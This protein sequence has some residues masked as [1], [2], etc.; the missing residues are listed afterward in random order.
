LGGW[1]DI[2]RAP[3]GTAMATTATRISEQERGMREQAL[4]STIANLRIEN[5]RLDDESTR[6]CLRHVDGE[7]D[8]QASAAQHGRVPSLLGGLAAGSTPMSVRQTSPLSKPEAAAS[9]LQHSTRSRRTARF[10]W[11]VYRIS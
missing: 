3:D 11:F 2:G 6:I 9:E 1:I 7:I 4:V 8:F 5:P 10:D